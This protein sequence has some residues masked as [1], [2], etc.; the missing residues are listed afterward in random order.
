MTHPLVQQLFFTRSEFER[1]LGGVTGAEAQKRFEN[2]N[3]LSWIVGHLAWQEQRYWLQRAQGKVLA[4]TLNELLAYGKPACTPPVEEMWLTWRQVTQAADPWLESLT[5]ARLQEPLAEGLSSAGT[6][7]YRTIYHYWYHLGEGMAVR[8][9]LGHSGLPEFVGNQDDQAPYRA[10]GDPSQGRSQEVEAELSAPLRVDEL[11][12]RIRS[13]RAALEAALAEFKPE[14]MLRA[15]A[16]GWS[17]KDVIAH[18][19]WHE[20][21]MLGVLQARA[22]VGSDL[23]NQ[24]L[25]ERNQAI[26]QENRDLPL[27]TVLSEARA[28]YD[29]LLQELGRLE[30]ADLH[31]SARFREMPSEWKPWQILADNTYQHYDDHR[32]GLDGWLK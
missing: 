19:T 23:W 15:G 6:F 14:D 30:D 12:D 3:C 1:G 16:G 32:L 20:R 10:E 29:S 25:E 21:Q 7:V 5:T 4:P 28:T 31:D 24:P 18:I 26:Y 11:I 17:L 8:Q 27:E 2:M 9:L 13:S 22:L